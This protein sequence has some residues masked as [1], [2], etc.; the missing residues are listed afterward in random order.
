MMAWSIRGEY[1]ENCNCDLFCPC[2]L[3]PRDAES[4]RALA[5]PTQ[6]HCDILLLFHIEGGRHDG[7]ALDGLNVA[8]AYHIPG[9][10]AHGDWSIATYLDA[11]AGDPQREALRRIFR[12]EAGG[13]MARVAAI[14]S[15]WYEPRT[16]EIAYA[17]DGF[18]RQFA[19]R[20]AMEVEVEG[21]LGK[22]GVTEVWVRN[23]HHGAC[24][25]MA[26]AVGRASR[27][28]DH[29]FTW[30]HSGKNAHYGPFDWHD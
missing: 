3:G 9:I 29:G 13:P 28:R 18:R 21:I 15:R 2:L 6:G 8:L 19:V 20:G 4:K 24:A 1:I 7:V 30:D 26:S 11:R 10:M 14:V 17:R 23:V 22:D 12:G 25:T 16:A 5:R 27:Y